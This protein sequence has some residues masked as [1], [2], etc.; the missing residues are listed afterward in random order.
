[1]KNRNSLILTAGILYLLSMPFAI[2]SYLY[3]PSRILSTTDIAETINNIILLKPL[4]LSSIFSVY[5]CQCLYIVI[6][7]LLWA[8]LKHVN[9][10][11]AI[12]MVILIYISIPISFINELN[13]FAI[14]HILNNERFLEVFSKDQLYAII[15][16][17]LYIRKTGEFVA[18]IFW[19]LWLLPMGLLV[20]KSDFIPKFIGFGLII[21]C[22]G[23]VIDSM[24]NLCSRP[25][26]FEVSSVTG[27]GEILFPV[28]LIFKGVKLQIIKTKLK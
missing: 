2:W 28:W 21:G 6:P 24:F 17:F 26:G 27:V 13:N 5:I 25:L 16:F 7:F 1:M 23:Y 20:I 18:Q 15:Q 9:K 19:G 11:M 10:V 3:V 12:I 22:F 4:F 8:L 14:L